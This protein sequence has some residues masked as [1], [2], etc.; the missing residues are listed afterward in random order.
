MAAT[1]GE[2]LQRMREQAWRIETGEARRNEDDLDDGAP[3]GWPA[4]ARNAERLLTHL[5]LDRATRSALVRLQST[6]VQSRAEDPRLRSMVATAGALGDVVA[7]NAGIVM[8]APVPERIRLQ[9][10]VEATLHG[11]A[12]WASRQ[13]DVS[14][15]MRAALLDL[16]QATETA[17]LMPPAHRSSALEFLSLTHDEAL[18]GVITKWA[19]VAERHLSGPGQLTSYDL[20]S[21]AGMIAIMCGRAAES[22]RFVA[23]RDRTDQ[24]PE[25]LLRAFAA[26]RD[27]A[28]WPD[29]VRL[30]VGKSGDLRRATGA[31]MAAL[32]GPMTDRL[33]PL[34]RLLVVQDGV[35]RAEGVAEAHR[36]ALAAISTQRQLWVSAA[37]LSPRYLAAHPHIRPTGWALDPD[38]Q[39]GLRL[40]TNVDRAQ[41][42]LRDAVTSLDRAALI[43]SSAIQAPPGRDPDD[44]HKWEIVTSHP[45]TQ[46]EQSALSSRSSNFPVS[47]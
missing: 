36:T 6:V 16:M 17:A 1:V 39:V 42:V 14:V 15:P 30:G 4:L 22:S 25:A 29:H 13:T 32:D 46:P 12:R 45:S 44:L 2:L 43:T 10:S 40:L 23:H 28:A 27:A 21:T 37:S 20:Q 8:R 35:H 38:G 26:W 47:L 18:T 5:E 31:L 24:T 41:G 34:E 11:L 3:G 9:I 7:S 19:A 33:G